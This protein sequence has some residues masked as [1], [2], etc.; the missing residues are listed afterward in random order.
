MTSEQAL[1]AMKRQADIA[2]AATGHPPALFAHHH[3][4]KAT[5]VLEE[6]GLFATLQRFSHLAQQQGGEDAIHHL[7]VPEVFRINH[8][9]LGQFNMLEPFFQ[10]HQPILAAT[11]IVIRLHRGGGSAKQGLGLKHLRQHDG[12]TAGMIAGRRFLLLVTGLMLFIHHH[13]AQAGE[14]EEHG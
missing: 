9:N 5:A 7:P 2:L 3:R 13:Q 4:G 6:D 14:G 12:H 10:F 1:G 11:G 8:N